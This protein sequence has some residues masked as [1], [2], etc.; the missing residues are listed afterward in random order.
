MVSIRLLVTS[1]YN[2]GSDILCMYFMLKAEIGIN[3][4]LNLWELIKIIEEVAKEKG[5]GLP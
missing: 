2:A 3:M 1:G 5:H 4:I